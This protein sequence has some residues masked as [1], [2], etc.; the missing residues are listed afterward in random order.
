[1]ATATASAQSTAIPKSVTQRC[2]LPFK[3]G[4]KVS[5]SEGAIYTPEESAIHSREDHGAADLAAKQ[6]TPVLAPMNGQCF[7][8]LQLVNERNAQGEVTGYGGGWFVEIVAPDGFRVQLCHLQRIASS[9]K[10]APPV[11]VD[12]QTWQPFP[13]RE[14]GGWILPPTKYVRAGEIIGWVGH[15]G[16]AKGKIETPKTAGKLA[17]WDEDHV[18]FWA[19]RRNATGVKSTSYDPFGLNSNNLAEYNRLL[20]RPGKTTIWK[21]TKD[22]RIAFAR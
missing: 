1:M 20:E 10:V 21:T 13:A 9:V 6:G 2:F 15:S 7:G 14:G 22:G 5:V 16:L 4:T 8:G 3:A 19:G 11:Q 18:H 17:S 12:E